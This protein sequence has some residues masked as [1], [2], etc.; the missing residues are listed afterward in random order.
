MKPVVRFAPSPTGYLHVGG[1]R[2]AL[3]NWLYARHNGGTFHL[4]IEDTDRARSTPDAI[5]KILDGLKWLGLDWDGP[6]VYQFARATRHAEVAHKLL[7]EDKAYHCYASQEELAEM[8]EKAKAEGKPMKYDGRWRDRDPSEAP[9]G[10]K[11]VVRLKA[12]TE[13]ETVVNDLV[14]GEIRVANEQLDDM[15]LLRSDGTPTYMLSVVVDDHDMGITHVIR[16]QDHMTNTFRQRQ[17]YDACGWTPP[18]FGHIPLIHGPDGAKLSK[19]HG[20]LGVEAYRD[21]GFLPEAMCNY[22]LRLG[23]GH[24]DEEIVTRERAIEL[25]D[26]SDVGRS[27]ARFDMAKLTNLNAHYMRQAD[28]ARLIEL[29]RPLLETKVGG[30]LDADAEQRLKR[31]LPGLKERARTLLELA[32]SALFLVGPVALPLT[33][34]AAKVLNAD[35][36]TLLMGLADALAA[37]PA[38]DAAALEEATRAFA[39]A[40]GRK[41]GDVAQPARAALTS[42]TV[43]P[44]IFDVMAAFGREET[45][46][47]LGHPPSA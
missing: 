40:G 33:D 4:R 9:P 44:P 32:D 3:F 29:I 10:V 34:K 35:A 19:R 2:T 17:L 22:L 30:T 15:V 16:G 8:R 42:S 38:W 41:L 11:P 45:L 37:A 46:K 23:W 39:E 26:L 24:G 27:P 28:D 5:A 7:A 12:P 18:A 21:M 25:F 43:S 1:A 13:G 14:Q 31:M 20:A 36:R 47:R 6:E